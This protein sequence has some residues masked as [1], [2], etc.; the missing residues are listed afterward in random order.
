MNQVSMLMPVIA[1][2]KCGR[3]PEQNAELTTRVR[4]Y[5]YSLSCKCGEEEIHWLARA[6]VLITCIENWNDLVTD[7][8]FRNGVQVL[9]DLADDVSYIPSDPAAADF[10]LDM[11]PERR[12]VRERGGHCSGPWGGCC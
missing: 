9:K 1:L 7:A 11:D 10:W 5:R 8:R 2:C 4:A 12:Y 3:Q 6:N